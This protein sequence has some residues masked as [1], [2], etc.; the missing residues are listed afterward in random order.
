MSPTLL[1]LGGGETSA[2]VIPETSNSF[3]ITGASTSTSDFR[4]HTTGSVL[5]I[6][7][8]SMSMVNSGT[9]VALIRVQRH[10]WIVYPTLPWI[11]SEALISTVMLD[12]ATAYLTRVHWTIATAADSTMSSLGTWMDADVLGTFVMPTILYVAVFTKSKTM[13]ASHVLSK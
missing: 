9:L 8:N 4:A 5:I 11:I 1:H 13:A 2:S 10:V 6:I 7:N 3:A 12:S